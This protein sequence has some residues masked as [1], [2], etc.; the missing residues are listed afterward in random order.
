MC[1]SYVPVQKGCD[2]K[3]IFRIT[4]FVF[5]IMAAAL[6]VKSENVLASSAGISFESVKSQIAVDE[7]VSIFVKIRADVIPGDFQ[8]FVTYDSDVLEYVPEEELEEIVT[9]SDGILRINDSV[10]SAEG[11]E[12]EYELKFK[13][14]ARGSSQITMRG[15]PE[16]YEYDTG[17]LM[18][19]ASGSLVISVKAAESASN[20]NSLELIKVS[21]GELTP[22]F[23]PAVT[24]YAVE[25]ENET[26]KLVVSAFAKDEKSEVTVFGNNALLVGDNDVEICVTAENGEIREYHIN[27]FRPDA[28]VED[29]PEETGITAFTDSDG[30]VLHA[31]YTYL[32]VSDL[33]S[34]E[35]PD[36]YVATSVIISG[37]NV[38]AYTPKDDLSCRWLLMPL[39]VNADTGPAWYVYDRE[40]KTVQLHTKLSEVKPKNTQVQVAAQDNEMAKKYERSVSN[41]KLVIAVLSGLCVVLIILVIRFFMKSRGMSDNF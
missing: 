9:G 6:S 40:E 24:Q 17:Y 28:P 30:I 39:K 25:V 36:G 8:G 34:L 38:K 13:G 20:E 5:L 27:V 16:L 3:K 19:V 4:V 22:V 41:M 14:I 10:F 37:T 35:V 23:D 2:M 31:N 15:T 1:F 18:S 33:G 32:V 29:E 21:P 11:K 26:T 7:E 12:R